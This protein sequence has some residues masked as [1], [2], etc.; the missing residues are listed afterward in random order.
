MDRLS[1]FTYR[2][3][4]WLALVLATGGVLWAFQYSY[5]ARSQADPSRSRQEGRPIPVRTAR[6]EEAQGE[7]VIGATAVT[8]ASEHGIVTLGPSQSLFPDSGPAAELKIKAVHVHEGDLVK[9]G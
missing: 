1:R 7:Q 9:K 6:V 2:W 3:L 4:P 8:L 5:D